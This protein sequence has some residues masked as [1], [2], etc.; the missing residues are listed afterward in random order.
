MESE[1]RRKIGCSSGVQQGE[2]M[3]PALFY[4]PLLPVLKRTRAELEPRAVEVF[5]NLDDVSIGRMEMT[6]DTEEGVP[7]L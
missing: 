2:A 4:M 3:G 6:P 1:E 7:F 5:V